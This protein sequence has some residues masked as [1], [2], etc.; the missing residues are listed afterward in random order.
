MC[1]C[2]ITEIA[3]QTRTFKQF[4]R[5][6]HVAI[7]WVFKKFLNFFFYLKKAS[8]KLVQ[9]VQFFLLR[10]LVHGADLVE[11]Y[12]IELFVQRNL[13]TIRC[14]KNEYENFTYGTATI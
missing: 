14:V 6:I 5:E 12:K 4:L 7:E 11:K 3:L 2:Y 9:I 10:T 8:S 1:V 13:K